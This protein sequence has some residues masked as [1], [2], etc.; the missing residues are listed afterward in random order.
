[1]VTIQEKKIDTTCLAQNKKII[2]KVISSIAEYIN[3]FSS[4]NTH[5]FY[6]HLSN[7]LSVTQQVTHGNRKPFC[8]KDTRKECT[9]A[10]K[11]PNHTHRSISVTP[12]ACRNRAKIDRE[13]WKLI[14]RSQQGREGKGD[15][16]FNVIML[17]NHF[18]VQP[19]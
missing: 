6:M 13:S 16:V 1:M 12:G 2:L 11:G 14:Q 15:S 10:F 8:I 3:I 9:C 5:A 4:W 18:C 7:F 19:R 17:Q